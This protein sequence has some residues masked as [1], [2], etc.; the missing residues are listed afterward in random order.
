MKK[1][2]KFKIGDRVAHDY[3][4]NATVEKIIKSSIDSRH[5]AAYII[6]TDIKP[7]VRYNMGN[8]KCLVWPNEL[9]LL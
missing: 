2:E 8:H 3:L 1:A 4:G 7:D 5:V 6:Y 9:K